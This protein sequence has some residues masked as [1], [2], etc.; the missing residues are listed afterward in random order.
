MFGFSGGE[1]AE[2]VARKKVHMKAAQARWPFLTNFDA[3]TIK[4]E[5]Q[6]ASMVKDR[7]GTSRSQAEADVREWAKDKRS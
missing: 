2:T 6:L 7:S 4:S 1:S 3:S 5:G